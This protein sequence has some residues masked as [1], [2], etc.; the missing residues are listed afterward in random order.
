[1]MRHNTPQPISL[2]THAVVGATARRD[3]PQR[4]GS[5][6]RGRQRGS[7]M[8][9]FALVVLPLATIFL[10]MVEVA[11][12]WKANSELAST[13]RQAARVA[14]H[15]GVDAQTDRAAL[16]AVVAGVGGDIG[17]I[18]YVIIFDADVRPS[19]ATSA[20]TNTSQRCNKFTGT[21]LADL[22][23]DA[24]WG[25]G[26][27]R[28]DRNWCPTVRSSDPANPDTLGVEIVYRHRYLTGFFGVDE[29]TL[30]ERTV[31]NLEPEQ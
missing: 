26:A 29:L 31:M 9:E 18:D 23:V 5:D 16:Q 20:C 24:R 17:Q 14:S 13:S 2:I 11:S 19:L 4:S 7:I 28:Y 12:A 30:K 27:G 1:M 8:V 3:D 15:L 22:G 25:C 6:R 10:G 21:A